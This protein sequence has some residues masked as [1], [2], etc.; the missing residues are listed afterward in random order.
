MVHY[1][2]FDITRQSIVALAASEDVNVELTLVVNDG[3]EVPVWLRSLLEESFA[4]KTRTLKMGSGVT[5]YSGAL[6][7]ATRRVR[8]GLDPQYFF[9]MNH[10]VIVERG[11]LACLCEELDRNA[12]A[13]AVGPVL[14]FPGA[15]QNV[16]NAGSVIHWPACRPGSLHYRES[17]TA[18]PERPYAVDYL[19]GAAML[20]KKDHVDEIGGWSEDYFLYFEDADMGERIRRV[21]RTSVVVPTA[22]AVHHVGSASGAEPDR[23]AYYRVR[24]RILFSRRWAPPGVGPRLRRAHFIFKNLLKRGPKA[25]GALAGL[26]GTGG[27]GERGPS[28]S[29]YTRQ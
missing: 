17:L 25:R 1:G 9:F 22:R 5:G 15:E 2:D 28:V 3:Q 14:L 6:N 24:N 13:L 4:E 8:S 29:N 12:R 10:D 27:P 19:C 23:T 16:W 20:M 26:F 7:A 21:G 11:T 18:V